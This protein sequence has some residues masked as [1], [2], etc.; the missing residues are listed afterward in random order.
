[1]AKTRIRDQFESSLAKPVRPDPIDRLVQADSGFN[2]SLVATKR[3]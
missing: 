2:F 3:W 1:M